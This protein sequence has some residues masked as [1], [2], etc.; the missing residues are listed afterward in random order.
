MYYD[1]GI[2]NCDLIIDGNLA[3]NELIWISQRLITHIVWMF[4]IIYVFWPKLLK[5]EGID[6]K[7]QNRDIMDEYDTQT[8]NTDG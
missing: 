6:K 2:E 5:N 7:K 1:D 4:P 8:D 3:L